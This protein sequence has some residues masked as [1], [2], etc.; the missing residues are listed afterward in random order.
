MALWL[1]GLPPP[2]RTRQ[3]RLVRTP[4]ARRFD[5]GRLT[6]THEEV[7]EPQAGYACACGETFPALENLDDHFFAVFTPADDIGIDGNAHAE[8]NRNND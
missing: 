5:N 6:M 1:L 4:D 7:R 8:V 3:G 2:Q